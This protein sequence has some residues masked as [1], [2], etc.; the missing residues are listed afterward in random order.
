MKTPLKTQKN[1]LTGL[2]L[3]LLIATTFY[4]CSSSTGKESK[5]PAE[6]SA[7]VQGIPVDGHVLKYNTL[8]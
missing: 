4:A 2:G 8:K 7:K 6:A 1:L 3:A 5:A